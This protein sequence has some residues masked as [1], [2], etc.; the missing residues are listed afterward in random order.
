MKKFKWL[1]G[2]LVLA[3]M[4]M[5]QSCDD[6]DGYSIGDF[7]WD[8]ATVRT[9]GGGGYYSRKTSPPRHSESIQSPPQA[10]SHSGAVPSPFRS[11]GCVPVSFSVLPPD[12]LLTYS[13]VNIIAAIWLLGKRYFRK[14]TCNFLNIIVSYK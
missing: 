6:D 3:L 5:L 12:R 10:A 2:M 11:S 14:K 4:P 13:I 9:T 7:S 1:L 8:W